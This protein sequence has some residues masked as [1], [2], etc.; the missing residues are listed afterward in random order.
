MVDITKGIL[1]DSCGKPWEISEE[2]QYGFRLSYSNKLVKLCPE[3]FKKLTK[4]CIDMCKKE[5]IE[6]EVEGGIANEKN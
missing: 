3:C 2:A 1:C 5:N 6:Y 4:S